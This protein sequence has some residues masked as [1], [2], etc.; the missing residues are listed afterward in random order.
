MVIEPL[1]KQAESTA[2]VP[3]VLMLGW[4]FP[5][6]INGGLGVA[7]HDLCIAMSKYSN[8]TMIIPKSNPDFVVKNL[9]LIGLNTIDAKTL[10]NIGHADSYRKV[11]QVHFINTHL[12][13]YYNGNL[14]PHH[15]LQ[16]LTS[17]YLKAIKI[18][19]ETVEVFQIDD[20]YG[21]DVIEKV[22]IF[23]KLAAKLALSLDFDVIHAHDW[24]TMIAGMEIKAKTGKPLVMHIH[25]LE[26]DRGGPQ[27][28]GWVYQVEKR[29]ME[30]ADIL[31]PVSNF[32]GHVIHDYYHIPWS[33]I[34]P[35]HNG[36]RPVEPF[37]SEQMFKEKMVLFVGRLT[38]QKGPEFFVDIAERVLE[39]DQN[40][41]FVMAGTGE[42]F[43]PLLERAA[44]KGIAHRF[45]LT[46][47]LNL[48]KVRKLLSI[49]DVYVMPSL[50]EPFGLSAVE[51]V[52]FGIPA[53]ISKQ[54]GVSEVLNGSLK[55]DYWDIN[56]AAGYI[57]S[58]LHDPVLVENVKA[59]AYKDLVNI[60]WDN[61]AKKVID[62]Y[63]KFKLIPEPV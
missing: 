27:S 47:F 40:V 34:V 8:V 6:V 21:G 56:R 10:R 22:T 13:P 41:R 24:M 46:G 44:Q 11:K 18:G 7:C 58:L 23:G 59:D 1:S 38:R 25:S 12:N 51:A 3:K 53:V 54:S 33:K 52:Q 35:V 32:T 5:P 45:H 29:G 14:E 49:A 43:N 15:D 63:N 30:Y 55:F 17:Q 9:N 19:D 4:E 61:S 50:S 2:Y 62:G 42:Y 31:M 36:I 20:L 48:D 16:N 37:K 57:L 39:K 28:K 60:S 26:V